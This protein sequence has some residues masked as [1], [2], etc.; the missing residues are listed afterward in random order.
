MLATCKQTINNETVISNRPSWLPK[1]ITW[2][3][4]G[5]K[6]YGDGS[7]SSQGAGFEFNLSPA[8]GS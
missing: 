1:S 8:D 2:D 4:L 3:S 6:P 7:V 5:Q